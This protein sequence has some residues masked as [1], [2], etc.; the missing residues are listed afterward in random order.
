MNTAG[1]HFV[2]VIQGEFQVSRDPDVILSTILGSCVAVCLF[3]PEAH[4]GGMNHYLLPGTE[5]ADSGNKRYGVNAMELLINEL[6]KNGASRERLQAK[7][8]GGAVINQGSRDI[9]GANVAFGK[10]FLEH[11]GIICL[12]ESTGG[13]QAR[14]LHF[15]PHSGAARMMIVPADEAPAPVPTAAAKPAVAAGEI[16]LF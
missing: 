2:T 16:D 1:K 4:I 12:S 6:Q 9:G 13:T 7:L 8:F 3:D 5:G 15:A 14:R 11:E 10:E